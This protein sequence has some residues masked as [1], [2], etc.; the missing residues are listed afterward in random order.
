M[1]V[2][3]AVLAPVAVAVLVGGRRD[4]ALVA[5]N[6]AGRIRVIGVDV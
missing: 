4:S 2:A 5:A 6:I 3:R 1:P